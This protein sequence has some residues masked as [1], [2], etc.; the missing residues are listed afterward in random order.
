MDLRDFKPEK[1]WWNFG[2]CIS[3]TLLTTWT[4]GYPKVRILPLW[5]K[6]GF[7]ELASTSISCVMSAK[8]NDLG[9]PH[10]NAGSIQGHAHGMRDEKAIL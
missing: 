4:L 8:S 10:H 2:Y 1:S 3:P 7:A 6:K 5:K 9:D